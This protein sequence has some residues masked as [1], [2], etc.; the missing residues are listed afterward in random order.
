[1]CL[2][3]TFSSDGIKCHCFDILEFIQT[4]PVCV[5]WGCFQFLSFITNTGNTHLTNKSLSA[6]LIIP[7]S[8]I[9][10]SVIIESKNMLRKPHLIHTARSRYRELVKILTSVTF[11]LFLEFTNFLKVA[12]LHFTAVFNLHTFVY[13]W[14][15]T[16]LY[17]YKY[18]LF[19][20]TCI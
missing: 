6:S 17:T 7:L 5:D 14:S 4:L 11:D 3:S 19:I 2:E 20:H 10:R 16:C 12:N 1:M 18:I 13:S 8:Q 15:R 9:L